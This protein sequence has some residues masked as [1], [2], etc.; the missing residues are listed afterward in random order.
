MMVHA[1]RQ[2]QLMGAL[3]LVAPHTSFYVAVE[4]AQ[5]CPA[6]FPAP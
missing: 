3:P 4:G 2:N 6:L 5:R 1:G